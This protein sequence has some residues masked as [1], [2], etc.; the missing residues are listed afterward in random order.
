MYIPTSVYLTDGQLS[1]LKL[2]YKKQEECVLR[3][4]KD[5]KPNHTLKLTQTQV[6]K[7]AKGQQIKLSKTQLK[8]SGGFIGALLPLIAKG[9]LA[10]LA[11]L[12]AQR[13]AKKVLTGN[14]TKKKKGKG[15]LQNWE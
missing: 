5:Q 4:S 2:A 13:V 12:G 6:D 14:G 10:G 8:Q 7:I 3:I 1:K 9:A 15:V 11:S